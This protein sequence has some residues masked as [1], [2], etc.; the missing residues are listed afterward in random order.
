MTRLLLTLLAL[1][2]GLV[3]Q[4]APASARL[5]GAAGAEVTIQLPGNSKRVVIVS[6]VASRPSATSKWNAPPSAGFAP[7]R[8][9]A[10]PTVLPGID[11]A[12]E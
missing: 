3:A 5:G 12:R 6:Q 2:T 10:S 9:V 4:T 8:A 11:R 1:L 7:R